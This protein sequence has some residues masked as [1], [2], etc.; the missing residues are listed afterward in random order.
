MV[1]NETAIV[2]FQIQVH[3]YNCHGPS[4]QC[5][6]RRG[7]KNNTKRNCG[8]QGWDILD[9]A[10]KELGVSK[11]T[12]HRR[13]NGGKSR[14]DAKEPAQQLTPQEEKAMASWISASTAT[15]NPV[16]H[17]FICEMAEKLI[18]HCIPNEIV[19]Q[20]GSS[21]VPSFLRCHCHLKIKMTRAIETARIRNVTKERVLHLMMN[22]IVSLGSTMSV[23]TTFS[24][25]MK[26]VSTSCILD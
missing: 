8:R 17:D 15:G 7:R 6:G 16:Q 2:K 4:H 21:W 23:W 11:A 18:Q 5:K 14:S 10:A 13:L 12:L 9:H 26:R 3:V 1:H 22:F 20:L 25:W 24:T 19:P